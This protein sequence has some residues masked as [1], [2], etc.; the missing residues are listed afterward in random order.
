MSN[1]MKQMKIYVTNIPPS[2]L[3]LENLNKFRL[4]K[5]GYKKYELVSEEFGTHIIDYSKNGVENMY[6]IEPNLNMD[7]HLI[8]NY[9][10][11]KL[12]SLLVDKTEYVH[13]PVISQF[14]VD[15]ILTKM[16]CFEYKINAN[17]TVNKKSGIKLVIECL[18]ETN[19]LLE[20]ELIPINF[21]FSCSSINQSEDILLEE[22]NMFLLELN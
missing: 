21:Y 11:N 4:S 19:K 2:T 20:K 12:Y 9:K 10:N 13:I 22:I 6:R 18:E 1:L 3:N 14:P 7:L 15:Y 5:D 17:T 16:I 8:N